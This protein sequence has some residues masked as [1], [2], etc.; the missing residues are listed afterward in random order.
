MASFNYFFARRRISNLDDVESVRSDWVKENQVVGIV[1]GLVLATF[2][3]MRTDF[4]DF[5]LLL[6][7]VAVMFALVATANCLLILFV[8][9][10]LKATEFLLF[11]KLSHTPPLAYLLPHFYAIFSFLFMLLAWL[12]HEA[13]AMLEWHLQSALRPLQIIRI[14]GITLTIVLF[15][16]SL[17]LRDKA[18]LRCLNLEED[19]IFGME[20]M[21]QFQIRKEL[22]RLNQTK[23]TR[24]ELEHFI[25]SIRNEPKKERTTDQQVPTERAP[26]LSHYQNPGPQQ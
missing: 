5:S 14:I 24:E 2:M 7:D 25:Y 15:I 1:A 10:Q 3:N 23:Y 9:R 26:L 21:S 22:D 8:A 16:L 6:V 19:G 11:L 17:C 12:V 4:R 20:T 13:T 18:R